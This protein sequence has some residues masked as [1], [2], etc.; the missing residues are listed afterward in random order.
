[1]LY[2]L[3]LH[4]YLLMTLFHFGLPDIA[5]LIPDTVPAPSDSP[6]VETFTAAPSAADAALMKT[7]IY[8]S[9]LYDLTGRTA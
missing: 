7:D 2:L 5:P 4:P 9:I 8:N 3:I 1:M 6:F